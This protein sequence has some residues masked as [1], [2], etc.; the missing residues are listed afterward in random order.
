M[1]VAANKAHMLFNA[2]QRNIQVWDV[3]D[4]MKSEFMSILNGNFDRT[5]ALNITSSRAITKCH[6]CALALVCAKGDEVFF[7]VAHV[8]VCPT[9]NNKFVMVVLRCAVVKWSSN[10]L[11]RKAK[12]GM[13]IVRQIIVGEARVVSVVKVKDAMGWWRLLQKI[14]QG[15]G[16][17]MGCV[18]FRSWSRD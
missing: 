2:E 5:D 10:S 9:I 18:C 12:A 15:P 11:G 6:K 13:H 4:I 16:S 17:C 14:V 3:Y 1:F 7:G 8:T